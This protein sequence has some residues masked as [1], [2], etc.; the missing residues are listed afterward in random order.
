MFLQRIH[1]QSLKKAMIEIACDP[2]GIAIM[3]NKSQILAFKIFDLPLSATLILKQEA[4]SVG[5]EFATPRDCILA[6]K[7]HYDGILF[8]TISQ[9]QRI[10]KKCK[11][12]P[13]GLKNLGALLQDH[14]KEHPQKPKIMAVV[15]VTP[16]SF[17][18]HSRQNVKSA[19]ERIEHLMQTDV[20]IIDIGGA[21]SRPGSALLPHEEEIKRLQEI[22]DFILQNELYK[23]KDFSIDTYH[24]KT[25]ALALQKGFCFVNDV[26]GLADKEMLR[27]CGDYQAKVILM[28]TRGTPQE[29]QTLTQYENLFAQMDDFFEQK[30]SQLK[31][32]GIKEIVLDIGF[33]FAKDG[34][35]NLLLIKHL[36][37]FEKF[38]LPILVGASR[39]STIQKILQKDAR[40]AL[41][42]TL[43]LHF[44]ALQNGA[45]ILR[46]HDEIEHL[47]CLKIFEAYH[48]L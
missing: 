16:D 28:H 26:S 36:R 4:L 47:D 23:Q 22:L 10:A 32:V 14:L 24:A 29:M 30:I 27:V 15:N 6:K 42:G 41:S 37:H 17:Y 38:G 45:S 35:Q 12:Q 7:S 31:E 43:A 1:A 46:V 39:K 21:S 18:D 33:G 2:S 20:S 9:L 8:G 11:I 34:M 44:L 25:A 19:I 3:Q 40:E 48:A 5:G 13:F